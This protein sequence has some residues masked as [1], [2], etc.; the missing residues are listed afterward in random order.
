[1]ISNRLAILHSTE[2]DTFG[3]NGWFYKLHNKHKNSSK[4]ERR[5]LNTSHIIY[6][7]INHL[8]HISS[9]FRYRVGKVGI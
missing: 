8:Q 5:C 9:T 7:T 1:M 3:I 6:W 2:E 4:E